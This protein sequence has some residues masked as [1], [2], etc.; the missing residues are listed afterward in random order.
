[1]CHFL[2]HLDIC[3]ALASIVNLI[4][5]KHISVMRMEL[6]HIFHYLITLYRIADVGN[7]KEV[8]FLCFS[9]I[10]DMFV[11]RI[12]RIEYHQ[13]VEHNVF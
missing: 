8:K 10:Q 6:P 12:E 7:A 5:G 11:F 13:S 9:K 3:N 1:M 4:Q 2:H